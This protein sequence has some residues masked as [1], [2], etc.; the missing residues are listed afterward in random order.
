MKLF[1]RYWRGILNLT[2]SILVLTFLVHQFGDFDLLNK[3]ANIDLLIILLAILV[4]ASLSF[5]HFLRWRIALRQFDVD[6]GLNNGLRLLYI[7]YFFNQ[8]LPSS[9]GGDLFRIWMSRDLN[10]PV[11]SSIFSI[12][13]DR[14]SAL[15]G[16]F[17]LCIIL[18]PI[19]SSIFNFQMALNITIIS[20]LML[21]VIFLFI[22]FGDRIHGIYPSFVPLQHLSS[23]ISSIKFVFRDISSVTKMISL[24]ALTH[25]ISGFSVFL[26]AKSMDINISLMV[27]I[28]V[29]PFIILAT[30]IPISFAGWGLREGAAIMAFGLVG[31]SPENALSIS[32]L[33][34]IVLMINSIPGGIIWFLKLHPVAPINNEIVS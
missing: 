31:M 7:G 30:V 1:K 25:F 22:K 12:L 28:S 33:L 27:C 24:S 20:F 11:R 8:T 4:I 34:G 10:I 26:I 23:W 18:A 16:L 17:F 13:A 9:V 14:I 29:Y 19:I 3:F 15:I 5:L 6:I 2:F 32:I 21:C